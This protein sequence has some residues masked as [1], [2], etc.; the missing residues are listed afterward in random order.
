MVLN[1]EVDE[2]DALALALRLNYELLVAGLNLAT[3]V[4][5]QF[6]ALQ[7][8]ESVVRDTRLENQKF[9]GKSSICP[10]NLVRARQ[11]M[12]RR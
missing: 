9:K 1:N 6:G 2:D 10:R 4:L 8:L 12:P 3:T 5:E 11:E 7:T